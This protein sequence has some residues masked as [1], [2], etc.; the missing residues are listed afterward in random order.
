MS[1][2]SIER[3]LPDR[4]FLRPMLRRDENK[5]IYHHVFHADARTTGNDLTSLKGKSCPC[6]HR[7]SSNRFVCDVESKHTREVGHTEET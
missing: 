2:I 3:V 6:W 1:F 4:R 7:E 5:K